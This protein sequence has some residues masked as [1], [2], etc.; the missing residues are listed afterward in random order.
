MSASL[1]LPVHM[2]VDFQAGVKGG[3]CDEEPEQVMDVVHQ[4]PRD[5]VV[6]LRGE[7]GETEGKP[8][9][10]AP[11][12]MCLICRLASLSK[13]QPLGNIGRGFNARLRYRFK[14]DRVKEEINCAVLTALIPLS[15]ERGSG[16]ECEWELAL[17]FE[18]RVERVLSVEW[19]P[20]C[21]VDQVCT[22]VQ[23]DAVA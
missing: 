8:G 2:L 1:L 23:F 13:W 14:W 20:G 7:K 17:E 3:C 18:D 15:I 6:A 9:D 16:G 11:P 12:T 4:E 21:E 5:L 19:P 10:E 22:I